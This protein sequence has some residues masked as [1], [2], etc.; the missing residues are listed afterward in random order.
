METRV[1]N[2]MTENIHRCRNRFVKYSD[3]SVY[4]TK[5]I[6]TIIMQ[7]ITKIL[8]GDENAH[9]PVKVKTTSNRDHCA[10]KVSAT[11]NSRGTA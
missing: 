5:L 10:P 2:S 9:I 11:Q 3:R 4:A 1:L 8:N 7:T 6:S